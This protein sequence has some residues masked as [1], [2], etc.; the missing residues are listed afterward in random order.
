[1]YSFMF[2][3]AL[4]RFRKMHVYASNKL[5][6]HSYSFIFNHIPLHLTMKIP[7]HSTMKMNERLKTF[8][9]NESEN[10]LNSD[11]IMNFAQVHENAN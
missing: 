8:C 6:K 2:S 11:R 10:L 7:L 3:T 1:M 9:Y 5:A 4:L